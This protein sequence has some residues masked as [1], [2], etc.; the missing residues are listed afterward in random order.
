MALPV[1]TNVWQTK[2][3]VKLETN[4]KKQQQK[5]NTRK[6]QQQKKQRK[7][8]QKTKAPASDKHYWLASF[9]KHLCFFFPVKLRTVDL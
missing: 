4:K 7:T 5:Q 1:P 6:Q 9:D 8:K 2:E 3:P